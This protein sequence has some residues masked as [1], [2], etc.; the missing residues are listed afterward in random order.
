MTLHVS[1]TGRDASAH[2]SA[3]LAPT[4]RGLNYY[5]IDRSAQD[6]LPLYM[7][8]A[9]LAHLKSQWL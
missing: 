5:A 1:L 4:C 8:G 6:L 2:R 7:D 9:L 3:A